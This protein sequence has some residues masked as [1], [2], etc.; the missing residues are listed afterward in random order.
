MCPMADFR[1][2][3]KHCS[4]CWEESEV[5]GHPSLSQINIIGGGPTQ[6]RK[7]REINDESR[8]PRSRGE[9]QGSVR[10]DEGE[11][12]KGIDGDGKSTGF[13]GQGETIARGLKMIGQLAVGEREERSHSPVTRC[14]RNFLKYSMVGLLGAN[15]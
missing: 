3:K 1:V 4:R 6:R 11:L 10:S 7:P 13:E 2:A 8:L 9:V 12:T 14:Y 15:E 5:V